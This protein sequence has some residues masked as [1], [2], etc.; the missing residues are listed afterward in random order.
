MFRKPNVKVR[1][2]EQ[3]DF[4][5]QMSP[6]GR[7]PLAGISSVAQRSDD[8]GFADRLT[9][10]QPIRHRTQMRIE[11]VYQHAVPAVFQ[12]NIPAIIGKSGLGINKDHFTR[13]HRVDGIERLAA[14][15]ALQA[16]DIDPFVEPVPVT[17]HTAEHPGFDSSFDRGLKEIAFPTV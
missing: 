5:M 17:A 14:P 15:I 7:N 11:G 13:G 6:L 12:H 9:D 4:K 10:R 1:V 8:L 2:E 3:I 16:F